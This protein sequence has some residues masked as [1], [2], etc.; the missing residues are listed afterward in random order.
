[1]SN[2]RPDHTEWRAEQHRRA[3]TFALGWAERAETEYDTAIEHEDKAR[4][5]A[6]KAYLREPMTEARH[7]AQFHGVRSTEALK[8]AE[9]WA[10]VAGALATAQASTTVH[11]ELHSRLG[12]RPE[13]LGEVLH[14]LGEEGIST[15]AGR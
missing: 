4:R 7:L 13:L 8:L 5:F 10:R 11:A 14:A 1:M 15:A 12:D 2:P 6:G 9:M 3:Q